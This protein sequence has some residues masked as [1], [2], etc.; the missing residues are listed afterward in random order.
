MRSED[1]QRRIEGTIEECSVFWTLSGIPRAEV[2][3]MEEELREHLG[4][5]ASDGKP[6]EAVVGD[7]PR[8]FAASWAEENRPARPLAARLAGWLLTSSTAAAAVFAA[9]HLFDWTPIF[10][11]HWQ[12]L[13]LILLAATVARLYL[14]PQLVT[15]WLFAGRWGYTAAGILVAACVVTAAVALTLAP[16][17]PPLLRWPWYATLGLIGATLAL[18]RL[19]PDPTA[20]LKEQRGTDGSDAPRGPATGR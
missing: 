13:A 7:A 2:D 3:E 14:S 10:P 19:T 11:V 9:H 12:D 16:E 20:P 17:G 1:Q 15:R 8:A 6:V 18:Y 5:A 4:A